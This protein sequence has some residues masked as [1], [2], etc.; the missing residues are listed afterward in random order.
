[1]NFA[2]IYIVFLFASVSVF[3]QYRIDTLKPVTQISGDCGFYQVHVTENRNGIISN[4]TIQTDSGISKLPFLDSQSDN[5]KQIIIED[6]FKTDTSNYNFNI[7]L[8]VENKFLSAKAIF[9]IIDNASPPNILFDSITYQPQFIS[10]NHN[11][12]NFKNVRLNTKD[13]INISGLNR[14]GFNFFIDTVYLKSGEFYSTDLG[15]DNYYL[16]AN[17][18]FDFNI[19]YEPEND[20][21]NTGEKDYDTLVVKTECLTYLFPLE[22]YGAMPQIEVQDHNFGWH[23]KGDLICKM[24]VMFPDYDEGLKIKNPGSDTLFIH[25][26]YHYNDNSPLKL[27]SPSSPEIP[28]LFIPPGDSVEITRLC[29]EPLAQGEYFNRIYFE[30]NAEGPDSVC[31]TYAISFIN[32]PYFEDIN[33]PNIRVGDTIVRYLD[34]KNN[35]DVPVEVNDFILDDENKGFTILNNEVFPQIPSNGYLI[36][37]PEDYEDDNV[38]KSIKIPVQFSPDSEAGTSTKIRAVFNDEIRNDTSNVYNYVRGYG[39]I[40]KIEVAGYDFE[41]EVMTNT[42]HPDTAIIRIK[43]TSASGRLYIEKTEIVDYLSTEEHFS[44][45]DALPQNIYIDKRSEYKFRVIFKP[46]SRGEHTLSIRFFHDAGEYKIPQIK[47]RDIRIT[48]TGYKNLEIPSEISFE[49]IPHCNTDYKYL[50]IKNLSSVDT[51][52]IDS[53]Y[54]ENN[55]FNVFSVE[56]SKITIMPDRTDSVLINFYP[57]N[58]NN[59]Y[60]YAYLKMVNENDIHNVNLTGRSRIT[61]VILSIDTLRNVSPGVKTKIYEGTDISDDFRINV[62]SNRWEEVSVNEI[63]FALIYRHNSL[64]FSDI[65][66]PG[67]FPIENLE[68]EDKIFNDSLSI[69][70]V[71]IK[72]QNIIEHDGILIRPVFEIL[73]GTKLRILS[74]LDDISLGGEENCIDINSRTGFVQ[75]RG[76]NIEIR[77][78]IT[79]IYNYEKLSLTPNPAENE[80]VEVNYT[81][82]LENHTRLEL[83]NSTGKTVEILLDEIQKA[84]RYNIQLNTEKYPSGIYNIRII[85][86]PFDDSE[87]LIIIK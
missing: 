47:S 72:T 53:I 57:Y 3:S 38:I 48:G 37:Y 49:E 28:G 79:N 45:I 2:R 7:Y 9:V 74:E 32:G 54:I 24:P 12:F 77:R 76:C 16:R 75:L 35:G 41:P 78:I 23:F 66:N 27:S 61:T 59:V 82:G 86:G 87:K 8:E 18:F 30:S 67:D 25:N 34:F 64:R 42:V 70:S 84:G 6:G 51:L 58:S 17:Q 20:I 44:I 36:V 85:S 14:T 31:N 5:F 22:G 1:M 60:N 19:Y 83:L 26:F 10:F 63:E 15:F 69:L 65:I 55:L 50:R 52:Q 29:F 46:L 11:E 68:Y 81:I 39:F 56:K 40:P 43:N 13:S 71:K 33:F 80:T 21:I 4:D 73:L 62:F